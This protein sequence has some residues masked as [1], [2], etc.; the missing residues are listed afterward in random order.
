MMKNILI[1]TLYLAL[2]NAFIT[3]TIPSILSSRIKMTS[4]D[5]LEYLEDPDY[6]NNGEVD[7]DVTSPKNKTVTKTSILKKEPDI[8][9]SLNDEQVLPVATASGVVTMLY[10]EKLQFDIGFSEI[11]NIRETPYMH[12]NLMDVLSILYVAFIDI[13]Y[14]KTRELEEKNI[15]HQKSVTNVVNYIKYKKYI[16]PFFIIFSSIFAKNVKTAI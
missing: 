6:W 11:M 10:R 1:L 14:S 12:M 15:Y 3:P 2:T 8:I 7:W 13:T 9:I 5:P 16:V 4:N